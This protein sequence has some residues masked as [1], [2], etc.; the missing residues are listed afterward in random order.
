MRLAPAEPT[1]GGQ[2]LSLCGCRRGDN[3]RSAEEHLLRTGVAAVAGGWS[4]E[5]L[6]DVG[7]QVAKAIVRPVPVGVAAVNMLTSAV[8]ERWRRDRHARIAE[9]AS[10]G[11]AAY[12]RGV[13]PLMEHEVVLLLQDAVRRARSGDAN[14][15]PSAGD[16]QNAICP[17]LATAVRRKR[18]R[19]AGGICAYRRLFQADGYDF[20][21]VCH[22]CTYVP[23]NPRGA[24][25]RLYHPQP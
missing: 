23:R 12:L 22:I 21:C 20:P 4:A 14:P 25:R 15:W 10:D 2:P 18:K 17:G 1:R 16:I 3:F 19:K 11:I 13:R 8:N 6:A 9:V 24:Q 5:K 7:A